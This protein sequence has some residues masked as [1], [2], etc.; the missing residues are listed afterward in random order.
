MELLF[1]CHFSGCVLHKCETSGTVLW[2]AVHDL[3]R[4]GLM[5]IYLYLKK[6]LFDEPELLNNRLCGMK[7][8]CVASL[9]LLRHWQAKI[10]FQSDWSHMWRRNN[11]LEAANAELLGIK[12]KKST[13]WMFW[14]EQVKL[15]QQRNTVYVLFVGAESLKRPQLP[16]FSFLRRWRF[17]NFLLP[18]S[19]AEKINT[20]LEP[21]CK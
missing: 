20:S 2:L 11:V 17:Q 21:M 6:I 10:S 7:W 3:L 9:E 13:L 4:C 15:N 5:L 1:N 16:C 12:K 18:K 8:G 14:Q 19:F